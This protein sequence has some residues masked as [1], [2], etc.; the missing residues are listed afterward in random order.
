MGEADIKK[1]ERKREGGSQ[2]SQA[3]NIEPQKEQAI[4]KPDQ[5]QY[6]QTIKTI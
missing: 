4:M 2:A 6:R 3:S 1:E 5:S